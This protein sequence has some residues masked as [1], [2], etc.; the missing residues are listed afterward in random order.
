MLITRIKIN[1]PLISLFLRPLSLQLWTFSPV[2]SLQKSK[3]PLALKVTLEKEQE[4]AAAAAGE[5]G[6]MTAA[7]VATVVS[8]VATKKK[9]VAMAA[10]AVFTFG[11]VA[12]SH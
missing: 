2:S 10:A 12:C 7:A 1:A 4:V 11:N 6:V 8:A 9:T 3:T 5:T